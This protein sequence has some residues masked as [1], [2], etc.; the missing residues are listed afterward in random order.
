[1]SESSLHPHLFSQSALVRPPRVLP[2]PCTIASSPNFLTYVSSG[3]FPGDGGMV[4]PGMSCKYTI[5]FA[6]DSLG[7]YEDLVTVEMPMENLLLVPIM[8]KRPPPVLTCESINLIFPQLR[9]EPQPVFLFGVYWMQHK[10]LLLHI[11]S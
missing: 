1:M 2:Q 7:D 8:A 5:R 10:L 9:L 6:P 4:A 3:R 11:Q